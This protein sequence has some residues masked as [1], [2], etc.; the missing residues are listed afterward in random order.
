[1][2]VTIAMDCSSTVLKL[3]NPTLASEFSSTLSYH[4]EQ[5]SKL[6]MPDITDTYSELNKLVNACGPFKYQ[7]TIAET[8]ASSI[9]SLIE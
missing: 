1:M 3:L 2:K 8:G 7:T 9:I 6:Y 5:P 4:I